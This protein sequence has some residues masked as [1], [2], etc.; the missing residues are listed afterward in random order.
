MQYG[1]DL[2]SL[3]KSVARV[4]TPLAQAALYV[5][6]RGLETGI[7]VFSDVLGGENVKEAAKP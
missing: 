1:R 6:R 5:A 3:F 7:G 2:G 4:V